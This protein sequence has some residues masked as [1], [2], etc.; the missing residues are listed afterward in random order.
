MHG[1][2]FKSLWVSE[3]KWY[4]MG[5]SSWSTRRL[6]C[7]SEGPRQAGEVGKVA[8]HGVQQREFY[9]AIPDPHAWQWRW[10]KAAE[11]ALGKQSKVRVLG[12]L[13][14]AVERCPHFAPVFGRRRKGQALQMNHGRLILLQITR[15]VLS[16]PMLWWKAP[17]WFI[18]WRSVSPPLLFS[19]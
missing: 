10:N 12:V 3:Y 8:P 5:R 13:M 11:K 19:T 4:K 1:Q 14:P 9:L 16:P 18:T 2:L 17:N 7:C 15:P 6:C